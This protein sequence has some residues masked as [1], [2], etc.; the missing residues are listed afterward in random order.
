MN[1]AQLI[2]LT[3]LAI[4]DITGEDAQTFLQN[5][6]PGDIRL[7]NRES[8]Q[9]SGW[10]TAKGRLLTTFMLWQIDGGY[11][12]VLA[13]D[14]RDS[15]AKRLKMFVLR[16]KVQVTCS[17]DQLLGLLNPPDALNELNLPAAS[18]QVIQDRGIT[19]VRLDPGRCL[20]SGSADA[21]QHLVSEAPDGTVDAWLRADVSEGLPIVTQATTEHYVP[22]MVNL[23]RLGGVSFKKGCY[24][25]QEIVARTHYLG[26]I[27]RHLY[28]VSATSPIAAGQEVRAA[29]LNG[30]SCGSLLTATPAA[31]GSQW[32]ALA[33][34]QRDAVD[35][36]LSV[37]S[38]EGT[39]GLTL[40][41]LVMPES[42]ER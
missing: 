39:V 23:D 8:A 25:G 5:Q 2:P 26:K 41:G 35:G 36:A 28:R 32:L 3:H 30:Q 24:P 27:K 29:S 9:I 37:E 33:V 11:R 42:Q 12:L 22:Q 19:V 10:C 1:H 15:V 7:V 21:I 16:L 6:I 38:D 18:W 34:L 31:D 4:L 13:R 40:L 20:I 17:E 14:L